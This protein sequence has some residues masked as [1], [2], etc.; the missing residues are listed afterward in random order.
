MNFW[1]SNVSSNEETQDSSINGK[2]QSGT[3][4]CARV[5][6][7]YFVERCVVNN[8]HVVGVFGV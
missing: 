3:R 2:F 7:T 5:L 4:E 1:L 8:K 6:E